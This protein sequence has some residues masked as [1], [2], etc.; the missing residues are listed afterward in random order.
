VP[1]VLDSQLLPRLIDSEILVHAPHVR[2]VL[3]FQTE[4]KQTGLAALK[5]VEQDPAQFDD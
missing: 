4:R 1:G 3:E 5:G 2:Q